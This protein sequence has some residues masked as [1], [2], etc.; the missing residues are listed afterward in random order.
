MSDNLTVVL[1]GMS[2]LE[3]GRDKRPSRPQRQCLDRLDRDMDSGISRGGRR[4][5][6]PN[7]LQRAQ[8]VALQLLR[9]VQDGNAAMASAT[10]A[11]PVN[12]IPDVKQVRATTRGSLLLSFDLVFDKAYAKEMEVEFVKP[13]LN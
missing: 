11:Y 9:A 13:H 6:P 5:E 4:I 2:R 1:D 8:F 10:C 12:C 7:G 3:Y